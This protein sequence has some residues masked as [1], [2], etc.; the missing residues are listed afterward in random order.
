M[1]WNHRVIAKEYKGFNEIEV[2]FGIHEVYYND[3][4]VPDKCTVDAVSVGGENLADLS[5]TLEWMRMA[6]V[7]PILNYADFEGGG[8]YYAEEQD[9]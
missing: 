5:Q 4:G 3:D 6:L 7:Q 2:E 8:K 1:I 9:A